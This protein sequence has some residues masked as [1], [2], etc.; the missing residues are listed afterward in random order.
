MNLESARATNYPNDNGYNTVKKKC[1][2]ANGANEDAE[3]FIAWIG[4][5]SGL[6]E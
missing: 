2:C 6:P 1:V 5:I 3:D 4:E